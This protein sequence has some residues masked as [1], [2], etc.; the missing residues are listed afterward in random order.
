MPQEKPKIRYKKPRWLHYVTER[1][2]QQAE[3][4]K[5]KRKNIRGRPLQTDRIYVKQVDA[6]GY[7]TVL[8][9][10]WH[11]SVLQSVV[12]GPKR[13]NRRF[14]TIVKFGNLNLGWDTV[15]KRGTITL[16]GG[17][18]PTWSVVQHQEMID[19]LLAYA[20][21]LYHVSRG[22]PSVTPTTLR[23]KKKSVK[24]LVKWYVYKMQ[25]R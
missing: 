17:L 24:R 12:K 18:H 14:K 10:V 1:A 16:F 15:K 23:C 21:A 22:G 25:K 3:P 7:E 4:I 9:E 19:M 5:I 13:K 2:I 8:A 6:S 20:Y 11:P